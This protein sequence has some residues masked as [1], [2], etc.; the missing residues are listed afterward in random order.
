MSDNASQR[1]RRVMTGLLVALPVW[2]VLSTAIGLWLWNRARQSDT[3]VE[4]AKFATAISAG[5]LEGDLRKLRDVVGER[6]CATPDRAE[7]LLR[8]AAMVEGS[9][10][11]LN[12]GYRVEMTTGPETPNGR[13]PLIG[14]ELPGG[15][16]SAVVALVAYD[17][18]PGGE[19]LAADSRQ[20]A[21]LLAVASAV[22]GESPQRPLRFVFLPH[23][24]EAGAPL[25]GCLD[26]LADD[27]LFDG[28]DEVVVVGSQGDPGSAV[29]A[30]WLG[31]RGVESSW[32][33]VTGEEWPA[34]TRGLAA[35]LLRR[36][37]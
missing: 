11:P 32:W 25:D 29:L 30:D 18:G 16:G 26:Q 20:L 12:A 10:G 17:S 9:L 21:S 37:R 15:E 22:A 7:A 14:V 2:L 4:P 23:G 31:G 13:F 6:G 33:P 1:H 35:E 28:V 3:A 36:S 24:N 34:R 5:V 27:A 19:D 8:A